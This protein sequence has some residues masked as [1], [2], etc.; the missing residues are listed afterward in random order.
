MT[1]PTALLTESQRAFLDPTRE[2]DVQNPDAY[3]RRT[4]YDANQRVDYLLYDLMLLEH[5]GERDTVA[6]LY[7]EISPL[8]RLRRALLDDETPTR[9]DNDG[10]ED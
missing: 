8:Q 2:H 7:Y 9:P 3:L 10:A 1:A 6:R 5:A 4:R